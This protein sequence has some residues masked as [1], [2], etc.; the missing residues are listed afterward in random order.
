MTETPVDATEEVDADPSSD[1][2]P[3]VQQFPEGWHLVE[4]G[5]WQ[6]S[7]APDGLLMLPRHLHPSEVDDFCAAAKAAA[8]VG[9]AVVRANDENTTPLAEVQALPS[10]TFVTHTA[11]PTPGVKML[12][13][14]RTGPKHQSS[15]GRSKVDP[16]QPQP[17]EPA[18]PVAPRVGA[19]R[20]RSQ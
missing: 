19:R 4:A 6:V 1:V 13:Q 9:H 20:G 5:S 16:R 8:D 2:L 3:T 7:V 14:Q 15:I 17:T 12:V 11:E 18:A 10:S